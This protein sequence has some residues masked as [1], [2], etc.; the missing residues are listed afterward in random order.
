[1]DH[2]LKD[3]PFPTLQRRALAGDTEAQAAIKEGTAELR[4]TFEALRDLPAALNRAAV[5]P[6]NLD[7]LAE[8]P[9][10]GSGE[11]ER[12]VAMLAELAAMRQAVE[13]AEGRERFMVRVVVA[14]GA[15]GAVSAIAAVVAIV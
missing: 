7:A 15:F 12:M 4:P 10:P 11:R 9:A 14:S 3:V 13:A 2:P 1:M 5:P 6:L 8:L